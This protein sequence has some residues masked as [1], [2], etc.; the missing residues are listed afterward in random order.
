MST[1]PLSRP[2]GPRSHPWLHW[3]S[4]R[5]HG[6]LVLFVLAACLVGLSLPLTLPLGPFYWDTVLYLDGGNRVLTGQIPST[7]FFAPVGPLGYW[8]FA[9]GLRLFSQ[10]QPLL[11]AHW[12]MFL[13]TLPPFLPVLLRV[14]K[15]RP[16][17]AW[18]LLLPL[19]FFQLLPLNVEQFSTFPSFDGYGM[20]NRQVSQVLYVLVAALLFERR[21]GLLLF[22][23]AWCCTALFLLKITGFIVAGLICLLAF[24]AGRVPLRVA[25][26]A[27]ACFLLVLAGLELRFALVSRYILDIAA[28]V[29]LNEGGLASRLVQAASIHFGLFGAGCALLVGLLVTQWTSVRE[30]LTVLG[31]RRDLPSLAAVLDQDI[32]WLIVLLAGGIFFESQNTGDQAFLFLWPLLLRILSGPA[33]RSLPVLVLVGAV[34]LP[35]FV[36]VAHRAARALIGQIYYVDLPLPNLKILAQVNQRPELVE[37]AEVNLDILGRR[38]ETYEAFAEHGQLPIYAMYADLDFQATWLL[39]T[40]QAV[41]AIQAF[42]AREGVRFETIMTLNFTNPFPYLLDRQAPR[43]IAIGA[44]PSRAVPPPDAET[45][46]AVR[47]TDLILYPTCPITPANIALRTI[48]EAGLAGHRTVELSPCWTGYVREGLLENR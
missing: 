45:I 29:R 22:A 11:L 47:G 3:L 41:S 8:L 24:A 4:R 21:A 23:I 10:P 15:E 17:L 30:R 46:A 16:A 6:P 36:N 35:P 31:A 44:D 19:V 33:G 13:V 39:A 32:V 26:G 20:Y 7:D 28:L 5:G 25:L 38:K 48:Y 9:G 40:D 43:R 12:M 42:E 14:A 34:A 2:L 18:G 37:R 27:V 1:T